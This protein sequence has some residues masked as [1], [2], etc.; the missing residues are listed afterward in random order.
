MAAS[1]KK[2][3]IILIL[4]AALICGGL[5]TWLFYN[6]ELLFNNPS[7]EK[8]PV[9]GIDVSAHQGV[10]DWKIIST[11]GINFAFIKATEGGAFKDKYF[12][13]NFEQARQNGIKAGAYH[14]L[15]YDS[16]GESQAENFISLVPR[17]EG[18]LPP[19][20]DVEFYGGYDKNPVPREKAGEILNGILS[21]LEEYYGQKPII[22][23]TKKSYELYI[24]D[25]YT[26][27]PIWIR[28]VFKKPAL[29]DGRRWTFWQY[30]NRMKLKGYNGKEKF[31]DMNVFNGSAEEWNNFSGQ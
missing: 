12:T 19:A 22:Y 3:L 14:F 11:Q 1:H 28:D 8:Y 7:T 21:R 26:D 6:G 5:T 18:M 23:A 2:L 30:T 25:G 15:S 13:Q 20:V 9:R 10:I 17:A 16:N 31:I 27:Y 4:S 24:K 29:P